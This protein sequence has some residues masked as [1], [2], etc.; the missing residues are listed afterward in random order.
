[1]A[2]MPFMGTIPAQK[3]SLAKVLESGM[4]GY[5]MG[6]GLKGKREEGAREDR[7]IGLAEQK[8]DVDLKNIEYS[9]KRDTATMVVQVV[10]LLDEPAAKEFVE[11]PKVKALFED[12]NWP[13]PTD[14]HVQR[15][16]KE[17]AADYQS[18]GEVMPGYTQEQQNKVLGIGETKY[19]ITG[20]DVKAF[21]EAIPWHESLKP[22][23]QTKQEAYR[24]IK[25]RR[26]G[27][28]ST[29]GGGGSDS[30]GWRK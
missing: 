17:T 18:K 22:G 6:L 2:Q 28:F 24:K 3:S 8:L 30:M 23:E 20:E 26:I 15:T 10:K 13:L 21:K 29:G 19:K 25:A 12:L 9:K 27:Q 14:L 7:K 16:L 4:S 11:D 1:M 5:Q